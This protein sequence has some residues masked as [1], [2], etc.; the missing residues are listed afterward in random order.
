[1]DE[2]TAID[3]SD[4][5]AEVQVPDMDGALRSF[6]D[7]T[8]QRT[9]KDL[10][11]KK[12][13]E[14]W[15]KDTE[16]R[17]DFYPKTRLVSRAGVWFFAL[18]QKSVMGRTLTEIKSDDGEIPHFAEEVSK[19]IGEVIGQHLKDGNW[20]IVCTPKRRHLT[21]N[22]ATLIADEIGKE[23]LPGA[24]FPEPDDHIVKGEYC[25]RDDGGDDIC[26]QSSHEAS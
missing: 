17:C 18:W 7:S 26:H 16:A 23:L 11:G 5:L 3:M 24:F 4:L 10:F 25:K 8:R 13:R 22:F 15:D 1:M 21:R 12:K 9:V 6:S 19:L 20:C 14:A 2:R